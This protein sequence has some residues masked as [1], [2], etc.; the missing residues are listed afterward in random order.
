MIM[1]RFLFEEREKERQI[2]LRE[3]ELLLTR[4]WQKE[5]ALYKER[6]N[7]LSKSSNRSEIAWEN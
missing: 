4:Q 6:S 2:R 7:R 3:S 5:V 1:L